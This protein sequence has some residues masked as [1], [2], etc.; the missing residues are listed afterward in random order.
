MHRTAPLQL[1]TSGNHRETLQLIVMETPHSPV[2]LGH[3]WLSLH[4]PLV[5]WRTHEVCEWSPQCA[6][7]C[8]RQA[9][10]PANR[11]LPIVKMPP[12]LSSVLREY[13]D[14]AEAF[15][16]SRA[17]TL[18]PH[19]PYDCAI[20]LLPGSSPPRGRVFSLS[21]PERAAMENYIWESLAAGIIRPSTS[22]AGAGFFFVGKKDGSL[23]P[24]IDYRGLN[25]ITRLNRYLLPLMSA[26]FESLQS[27]TMFT[28]LDLRNAYHLVRVRE[29]DE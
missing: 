24:S 29:D 12:D 26:A 13:H 10:L 27:A 28:K 16:K 25:E 3:P 22:P 15:R 19:R 8:L 23:R 21:I 4:R 20:D 18:P 5:D 9:P 1:L 7:R 14:L 6:T 17:V 11:S 2:V